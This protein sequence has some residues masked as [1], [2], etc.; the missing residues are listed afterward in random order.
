MWIRH[1]CNP[2]LLY[3]CVWIGDCMCATA[4]VLV[5]VLPSLLGVSQG[6]LINIL[7]AFSVLDA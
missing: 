6:A 4:C 3:V 7:Q 2:A 5:A 1:A